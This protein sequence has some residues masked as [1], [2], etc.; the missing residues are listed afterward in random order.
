[1]TKSTIRVAKNLILGSLTAGMLATACTGPAPD[2]PSETPISDPAADSIAF[3]Q[4][5]KAHLN[6][7]E[8]KDFEGLKNTSAPESGQVL[9]VLPDGAQFTKAADFLKLQE[10]WFQDTTWT[11]E[12]KILEMENSADFGVAVV[13]A[14]LREPER[15]GK[16]YFHKMAISYAL[17]K[18][19]GA[20]RVVMD[21]AST[22]EKSE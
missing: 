8:H 7:V 20:W 18:M 6:A 21:H 12:M 10:E 11:M 5:L 2:A 16:P 22:I 17:R 19:E 13:E 15:N 9:W 3:R 14:M 1:M 4:A